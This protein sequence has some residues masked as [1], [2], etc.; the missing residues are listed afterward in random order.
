V[1]EL[2][3]TLIE[4]SEVVERRAD[5]GMV[6][7]QRLSSPR[8]DEGKCSSLSSFAEPSPIGRGSG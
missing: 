5:F 3:E 6:G 1:A 8:L 2:I 7:A 4:Q